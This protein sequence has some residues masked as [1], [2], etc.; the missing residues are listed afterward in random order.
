MTLLALSPFAGYALL[1]AVALAIVLL[2]LLKP[3]AAR[4]VVASTVVWANVL[5]RYT[6]RTARWRRLLSLLLAL[7]IGL[8]L[9][10]ALTRPQPS[11]LGLAHQRTVLILDNSP[12]MAARTH[13]G[14]SRW[15]H[16]QQQAR[17]ML[18]AA[19]SEVMLLDTMGTAPVSG[20]IAPAQ[21]LNA[22]ER[23]NVGLQR[24]ARLPALPQQ[25][26][27]TELHLFTDGVGLAEIPAGVVVHSA[28]EAADNVAITGLQARAFPTDPTRYEAFVQ[29]YNASPGPKRVNLTL[30]G[31]ERFAIK[32]ELQMAAGELVDASFD[33]SAFEGGI[34]AAAAA[35]PG[36][37]L[38]V[39]DIAFTRVP[40]HRSRKVLLVT[41]GNPRLE[42]SLRALPGVALN[43]VAPSA[44]AGAGPADAYVF[45]RF[46]PATPPGAGALLFRPPPAPWL[47]APGQEV[48][49]PPIAGWDRGHPLAAG[50]NW[51][52]LRVKRARLVSVP[53]DE[54]VVTTGRGVLIAARHSPA[55]W[56]V[57]GFAPQ[58]SNL[59]L[60]TGFPVLLGTALDWLS[61]SLPAVQHAL[62]SIEV[63]LPHAQVRDGR[64]APVSVTETADGVVFEAQRPDVYTAIAGA[65]RVQVIANVLDPR[66]A[67]I[68]RSIV[69][70]GHLAATTTHQRWS[71]EPWTL[72]LLVAAVFLL[73][74]WTAYVRR[75]TA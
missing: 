36:D 29:V 17:E 72:L 70:G 38:E 34:L 59:P 15:L 20:F 13:D 53:S 57:V 41:P 11:A 46:A 55:P 39:D 65:Q 35:A 68:N 50:Q 24:V 75:L 5:H 61:A 73:L 49:N 69:A 67:Q 25:E 18:T 32:Q 45:D 4:R 54:A 51:E 30:R 33:V 23:L 27:T 60:Q 9:A 64:G 6:A 3:R 21:A 40:V 42:D 37:A 12:S 52:D 28:F 43:V 8:S 22:L 58:D 71:I 19:S 44:Y 74:D 56:V 26:R 16:A 62:G 47:P 1:A 31:G 7:G 2:H 10:L 66:E 48:A 14:R 63:A